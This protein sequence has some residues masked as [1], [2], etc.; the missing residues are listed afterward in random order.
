M[1]VSLSD[2]IV[3]SRAATELVNTSP[4]VRRIGGEALPDTRALEQFLSANGQSATGARKDRS[5][6]ASDLREVIALR[7]RVR[8]VIDSP[9]PIAVERANAL[10]AD[11]AHELALTAETDRQLEWSVTT[12]PDTPVDHNLAVLIACGILGT[13]QVL[14][15]ERLRACAADDC[16]GAFIDTSRA[17][18][19]RYCSPG[20][21]GNRTNVAR[22]RTRQRSRPDK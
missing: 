21:C 15:T 12:A 3:G 22:Y 17:G 6:N 1:K 14:G 4:E 18:R 10:L 9:A 2:Y 7:E 5:P 19:R 8:D 16:N 20:L 11:H 13:I